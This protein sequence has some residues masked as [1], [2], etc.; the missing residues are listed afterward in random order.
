LYRATLSIHLYPGTVTT[1]KVMRRADI[2]FLEIVK[3]HRSPRAKW[4]RALVLG[5]KLSNL[6][7]SEYQKCHL[8]LFPIKLT[9]KTNII[10]SIYSVLNNKFTEWNSKTWSFSSYSILLLF[11]CV[12]RRQIHLT[13]RILTHVLLLHNLHTRVIH[14]THQQ[15]RMIFAKPRCL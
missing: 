2:V 15:R 4:F 1:R 8:T 13:H 7:N 12:L 14:L 3:P 11:T 5:K 10:H 9:S 6:T